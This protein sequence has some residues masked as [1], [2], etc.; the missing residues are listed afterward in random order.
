[1]T[2][3]V[4]FPASVPPP[5]FS[6]ALP[7]PLAEPGSTI[8]SSAASGTGGTTTTTGGGSGSTP[9]GGTSR[10]LWALNAREQSPRWVARTPRLAETLRLRG[11][12]AKP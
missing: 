7:P 1:M 3:T 4:T 9:T 10:R 6:P 2:Y 8:T 12:F 11:Q 5:R